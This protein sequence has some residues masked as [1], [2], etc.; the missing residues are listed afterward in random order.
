[1]LDLQRIYA[2]YI[3]LK[4]EELNLKYEKH[5]GW[6][7]ASSSGYC[8]KKQYYKLEKHLRPTTHVN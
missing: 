1:M 8:H 2:E 6:F 5:R 4:Q 7:G 3:A